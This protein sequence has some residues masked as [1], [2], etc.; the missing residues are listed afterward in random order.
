M[1]SP[2]HRT[3]VI[4]T[5]FALGSMPI[6]AADTAPAKTGEMWEVTSQMQMSMQG[7]NMDMPAQKLKACVKPG[8]RAAPADAQ[9]KCRRT[10][11]RS[12]GSTY[13]WKEVCAGP[14]E[15]KGEG[16]ITYSGRDSYTGTIQYTSSEGNMTT[17]LNGKRL[18][19]PCNP[20]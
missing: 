14:P 20:L 5:L 3:A 18:G 11:E 4:A 6:Q 7:M 12:A 15:M 9:H 19:T 13:T 2:L 17:K 1:T 10:D 16:K 8:E